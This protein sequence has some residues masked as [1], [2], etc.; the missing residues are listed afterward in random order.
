MTWQLALTI[1]L[2]FWLSIQI[3]T[4]YLAP[5]LPAAK[6]TA[7]RFFVAALIIIGYNLFL[8]DF[9]FEKKLLSI[10]LIGVVNAFG[11]YC[12]WLAYRYSL[13]KTVLFLPLS[14]VI[15]IGLAAIFLDETKIY[16][17]G[18]FL[19]VIMLFVAAFLLSRTTNQVNQTTEGKMNIKWLLAVTGVVL[20]VGVT[21]FLMKYFS[22]TIPSATFFIYWYSGSFLGVLPIIWFDRKDERKLFQKAAWWLPLSSIGIVGNLVMVYWAFQL[23]PVGYVEPIRYFGLAFLPILPGWF[24]FKEKKGLTKMQ[25]LGFILGAIGISLVILNTY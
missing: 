23:A 9:Q 2:T 17:I 1:A 7:V 4:R 6:S 16:N 22:L 19:G 14:G 24:I 8:G 15:T 10:S 3:L 25:I 13:S 21:I 11:A 5:N 20:I 18:I 12:L